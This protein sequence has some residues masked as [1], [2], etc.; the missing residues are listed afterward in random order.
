MRPYRARYAVVLALN[1]M[2]VGIECGMLVLV[3]PILQALT[4]PSTVTLNSRITNILFQWFPVSGMQMVH[5]ICALM[6]GLAVLKFVMR[7]FHDWLSSI[8]GGLMMLD[9]RERIFRYYAYAH[10]DELLSEKQGRLVHLIGN[11]PGKVAGVT[12]RIPTLLVSGASAISIVALL[13]SI[14]WKLML[15]I[16]AAS[17]LLLSFANFWIRSYSYRIGKQVFAVFGEMNNGLSEFINGVRQIVVAG[18]RDR[19]AGRHH[20]FSKKLTGLHTQAS[21][22]Q[23]LP[24]TTMDFLM[25][26]I[27]A[28][29]VFAVTRSNGGFMSAPLSTLGFFLVAFIR[30]VPHVSSAVTVYMAITSSLAE[31][32][33][34]KEILDRPLPVARKDATSFLGLQSGVKFDNVRFQ[35]KGRG[36]L[37][38]SLSFTMEKQKI[39]ALVGKSGAGKSTIINLLLGFYEPTE[40]RILIDGEDL[41]SY[42]IESW[43]KKIGYVSQDTFIFHSS[44]RD[45]ITFQNESYTQL[46]I[47][48]AARVAHAHDFI[49]SFPDGYDTVVG[50]RGM[51]LSGGQQQRIAIA[52][53]ILRNPEI[54]IF[55]EATSSL[56]PISEQSVQSAINSVAKKCTALIISHRLSSV[57]NADKILVLKDGEIVGAGAHED[58]VANQSY[59]KELYALSASPAGNEE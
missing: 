30:L 28:G 5:V 20:V 59:Y 36:G 8:T 10:L 40:G 43:R 55:D 42:D 46:E 52:R 32:E 45:N 15:V 38:H 3:M 51:K 18:A 56:D 17:L 48:N 54:L 33:A 12:I 50:E 21:M 9:L 53:A 44:I 24:R 41:S 37:F 19:W 29:L 57:Q 6:F 26:A 14:H 11:S 1:A 27:V 34:I 23:E 7:V 47:E 4:G 35:H 13:F 58:L 22:L 31:C 16:S 25:A 39:T 2:L 49:I